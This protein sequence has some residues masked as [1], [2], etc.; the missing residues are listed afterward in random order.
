[1]IDRYLNDELRESMSANQKDLIEKLMA[2]PYEERSIEERRE[3]YEQYEKMLKERD[4]AES[5]AKEY[6]FTKMGYPEQAVRRPNYTPPSRID[7]KKKKA[8]RRMQ[9]QSR[10]QR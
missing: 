5:K 9:K 10:R 7:K 3:M 1:M 8:K 2:Q 6:E 4:E